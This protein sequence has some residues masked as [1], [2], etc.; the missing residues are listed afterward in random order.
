MA[1]DDAFDGYCLCVGCAGGRSADGD[2]LAGQERAGVEEEL[3]EGIMHPVDEEL[4]VAGEV[5]GGDLS[6]GERGGGREEAAHVEVEAGGRARGRADVSDLSASV[7]A[8]LRED[9]DFVRGDGGVGR[10]N[11]TGDVY[12]AAGG[13]IAE[14]LSVVEL[15]LSVDLDGELTS[16][17]SLNDEGLPGDVDTDNRCVEVVDV[18]AG[19]SGCDCCD[20]EGGYDV[21]V[22]LTGAIHLNGLEEIEVHAEADWFGLGDDE[23]CLEC[24]VDGAGG[25]GCGLGLDGWSRPG[26]RV[27]IADGGGAESDLDAGVGG[28]RDG[29]EIEQGLEAVVAG[30]VDGG[31]AADEGD[32][33]SASVDCVDA[34][35]LNGERGDT[36]SGCVGSNDE[37]VSGD[38]VGG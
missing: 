29:V 18:P 3:G 13:E 26:L 21:A 27:E 14:G 17:G 28:Y 38:D 11:G 34:L 25:E 20:V 16:V 10:L 35:E 15:G 33:V 32:A 2:V 24:D 19:V 9:G 23:G 30:E 37:G 8:I 6:E 5:D 7:E 36:D 31:G 12:D 1:E 22:D 4:L